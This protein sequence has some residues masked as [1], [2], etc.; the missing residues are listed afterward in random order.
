MNHAGKSHHLF[1]TVTGLFI[2]GLKFNVF[3][4][5]LALPDL[6]SGSQKSKGI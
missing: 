2:A 4:P 5:R 1:D 3:S 6:P